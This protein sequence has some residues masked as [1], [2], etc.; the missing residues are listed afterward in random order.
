LKVPEKNTV[1]LVYDDGGK[2]VYSEDSKPSSEA[3]E[4]IWKELK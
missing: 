3:A 4:I 1:V 2:L